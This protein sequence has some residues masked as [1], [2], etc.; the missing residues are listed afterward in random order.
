MELICRQPEIHRCDEYFAYNFIKIN[1][2]KMIK[3]CSEK[4]RNKFGVAYILLT[5]LSTIINKKNFV[6]PPVLTS[7]TF[8]Y[9]RAPFTCLPYL[10]YLPILV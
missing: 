7:T 6:P 5:F 3:L 4:L 2:E 8:F 1:N 10:F 9:Y